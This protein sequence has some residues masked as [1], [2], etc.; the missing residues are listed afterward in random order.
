MTQ[1]L[2][3]MPHDSAEEPTMATMEPAELEAALAA[4]GAFIEELTASG[5][6]VFAGGLH[7]PSTAVTVDNTGEHLALADE[8]F[9]RAPEYLGGFWVI[10]APDQ[11][12]AV[13]WAAKASKALGARI[14]VRTF[15]EVP[16]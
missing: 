9:T 5:A 8:P 16:A 6:L 4:A 7:P 14:E 12:V 3:S 10:E 2:L 11:E 13:H 1:Y 15:Q